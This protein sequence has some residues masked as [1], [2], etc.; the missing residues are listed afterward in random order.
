MS[1]TPTSANATSSPGDLSR[2]QVVAWRNAMFVIFALCGLA[3]ASWVARLPAVRDELGASTLDMGV[4]IFGLSFGSILGLL[5]SS[6]VIARLGARTTMRIGLTVAPLGLVVAG[7]AATL[8]PNFPV[9]FVGLAVFGAAFSTTDVAMNVSG[10]A[11]ERALGRA[12]MPI[13]HAFFSFGTIAGA[14]IGAAAEALGVPIAVHMGFIALV[15]F[16]AG[17]LSLRFLQD[18]N[19]VS[20]GDEAVA[21]DDHSKSWRG[22]L[23]IWRDPRTLLI[24]LIVLGMAFAEGSANDWLTLAMVDGHD[25]SGTVGAL[26]FGVFVTAMTVGR[27]SGVFLLDRFGRVPV[28]RGSAVLA[29]VGLL[30]VIFGPSAE[31]AIVGI[32]LWGLG[33]S[34]GFPV[35]MSAAADDPKTAAARVSAVA[36]IGYCAFLVGPPIIGVLG[37][38]FGILH[39]LLVVLV[40]VAAAGIASSAAREPKKPAVVEA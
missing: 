7:L 21:A 23:S 17:Q 11:N 35:G 20:D 39:A 22:R 38:H 3:L 29:A 8:A 26:M 14:G 2:R 18:E 36:T 24:G 19:F 31:I 28:L 5:G 32:V 37:E 9:I 10:A 27:L 13:Y 33:S 34:L 6:H 16:A 4:L 40:L 25:V 15:I 30:I 1:S 12:I